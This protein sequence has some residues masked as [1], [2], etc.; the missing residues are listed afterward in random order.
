[1][2]KCLILRLVWSLTAW[3]CSLLLLLQPS[4]TLV[5]SSSCLVTFKTEEAAAAPAAV[6]ELA[7]DLRLTPWGEYAA[8]RYSRRLP[9]GAEADGAAGADVAAGGSGDGVAAG[10][11]R[12]S[13][14]AKRPRAA[15]EADAGTEQPQRS[16]TIM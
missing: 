5:D 1:V 14:A 12:S 2:L 8:A 7:M 9:D 6:A 16:C 10:A 4:V 3:S 13:R 15:M 11:A